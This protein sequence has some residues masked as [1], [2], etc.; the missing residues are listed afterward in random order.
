[1]VN[2]VSPAADIGIVALFGEDF[3]QSVGDEVPE[4][5]SSVCADAVEGIAEGDATRRSHVKRRD[6]RIDAINVL[7][8][9]VPSRGWY[10]SVRS[11]AWRFL[12][13]LAKHG[14]SIGLQ[15]WSS[16]CAVASCLTRSPPT[17]I[18]F[19]VWSRRALRTG[20][21]RSCR[22]TLAAPW[23]PAVARAATRRP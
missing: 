22:L 21:S 9:R 23:M 3:R 1:M 20:C 10:N 14:T 2:F 18:V 8:N 11:R 4:I 13:V 6:A 16:S 19:L 15:L 5:G 12:L 7:R 17:T